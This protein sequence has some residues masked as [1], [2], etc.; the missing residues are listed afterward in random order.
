VIGDRA[1]LRELPRLL[2]AA[3]LA[4]HLGAFRWRQAA[5]VQVQVQVQVLAAVQ[6]GR[7]LLG[8][9]LGPL[10]RGLHPRHE[11]SV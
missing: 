5:Q 11:R 8:A 2:A 10:L 6:A 1:R 9:E 3:Q 7:G 4:H